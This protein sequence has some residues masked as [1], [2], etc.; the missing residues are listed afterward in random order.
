LFA[1]ANS[2]N[3][4]GRIVAVGYDETEFWGWCCYCS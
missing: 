4:L 2:M 1:L 3:V